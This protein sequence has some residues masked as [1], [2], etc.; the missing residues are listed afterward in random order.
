MRSQDLQPLMQSGRYVWCTPRV[1]RDDDA[2]LLRSHEQTGRPIGDEDFLATLEE[3]L[4]RILKKKKPGPK[5][6]ATN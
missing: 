5:N 2:K 1:I 3:N 4:G 6:R